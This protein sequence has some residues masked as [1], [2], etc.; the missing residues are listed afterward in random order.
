MVLGL[1]RRGPTF[2]SVVTIIT[3]KTEMFTIRSFSI[4]ALLNSGRFC[5]T[6]IVSAP[7]NVSVGQ[8]DPFPIKALDSLTSSRSFPS[9]AR[10]N[11][12]SCGR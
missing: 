1:D 6:K 2:S 11:F 4:E 10:L 9:H 7:T 5:A 8:L 12:I 3:E